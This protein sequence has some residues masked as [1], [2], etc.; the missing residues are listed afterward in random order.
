MGLH[1]YYIGSS[2][3]QPASTFA[4]RTQR[5]C[6]VHK[7]TYVGWSNR[8]SNV[9]KTKYEVVDQTLL[10]LALL[11]SCRSH[12]WPWVRVSM[13][14]HAFPALAS[15]CWENIAYIRSKNDVFAHRC[16]HRCGPGSKVFARVTFPAPFS[17]HCASFATLRIF[18]CIPYADPP[19]G[20]AA[21]I[22]FPDSALI[23]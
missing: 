13:T 22:Y 10:I 16:K 21:A 15:V 5:G 7:R 20:L 23:P 17:P 19:N 3:L 4:L 1:I 18:V 2:G 14:G 12:E 9:E 8:G 6:P 11:R